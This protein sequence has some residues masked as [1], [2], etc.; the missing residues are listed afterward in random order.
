MPGSPRRP[1]VPGGQQQFSGLAIVTVLTLR[2]V[3]HLA[4]RQAEGFVGSLI[5]LM[6][7]NLETPD[8]TTLSQRS[9][10]VVA[11]PPVSV[12]ST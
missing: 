7:L 9:A 4:L 3:F 1:G 10:T 12:R 6:G 8:H 2:T 11:P 5:H